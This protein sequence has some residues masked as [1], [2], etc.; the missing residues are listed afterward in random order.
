MTVNFGMINP[1][2][3]SMNTTADIMN[4]PLTGVSTMGMTMPMMPT[5]GV[6]TFGGVLSPKC[7][8]QMMSQWDNFGIDRQV[9]MYKNNN[10]AQFRMASQ[11]ETISRQIQILQ[12]EIKENNL[13]NV[14]AEYDKLVL[15]VKNSYGK[16]LST[17]LSAE[18]EE[19]QLKAYAERL[20]SQQTGSYLADDIKNNSSSSF[21]S[22]VKKI[23]S[24]GFSNRKTADETVAYITGAKQTISSKAAKVAGSATAGA[25]IG[26]AVGTFICPGVGTLIGAGIGAVVTGL[27]GGL[28]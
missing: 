11:N 14:K 24:F 16:Q 1:Y 10:N 28:T 8:M 4:A 17:G 9:A 7:Q 6:G 2:M 12:N 19:L 15:A 27:T 5:Y 23:L 26:A 3:Y 18:E 13:D 20:Y 25:G 21:M 22:G